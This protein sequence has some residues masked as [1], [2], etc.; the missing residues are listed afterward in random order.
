MSTL[1]IVLITGIGST[2]GGSRN[3]IGILFGLGAA[4]F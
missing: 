2:G 3:L 1:G 4:C